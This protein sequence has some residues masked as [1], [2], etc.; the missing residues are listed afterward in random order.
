VLSDWE[1]W[2]CA[3]EVQREHGDGAPRFVA[4]RIGA[5]VLKGDVAGVEAWK[6]IAIR[7]QQLQAQ[8][9]QPN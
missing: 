1:L 3:L 5:L 4:E 6:E 2:A 7:L 8:P 9:A